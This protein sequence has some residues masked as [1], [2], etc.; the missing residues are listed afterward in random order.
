VLTAKG[1]DDLGTKTVRIYCNL[2]AVFRIR[3]VDGYEP[4]S[5]F[6]FGVDQHRFFMAFREVSAN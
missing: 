2:P 6:H 3:N 1:R 4:G 5:A